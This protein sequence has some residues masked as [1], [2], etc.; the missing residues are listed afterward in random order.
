MI[1]YTCLVFL[2]STLSFAVNA[3]ETKLSLVR[4]NSFNN[5]GYE[6]S[7]K[8]N[9]SCEIFKKIGDASRLLSKLEKNN[10][11]PLIQKIADSTKS[12]TERKRCKVSLIMSSQMKK[13]RSGNFCLDESRD[14]S[15]YSKLVYD[16]EMTVTK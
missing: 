10:C 6:I 7:Q 12:F 5:E 14:F 15:L 8:S 4:V 2:V 13:V 16:L 1:S 9:Q 11:E 3:K